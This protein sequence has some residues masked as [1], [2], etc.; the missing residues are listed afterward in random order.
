MSPPALMC[1]VMCPKK[2]Y[3]T[4][5]VVIDETTPLPPLRLRI[6]PNTTLRITFTKG[7]AAES[8]DGDPRAKSTAFEIVPH[9]GGSTGWQALGAELSGLRAGVSWGSRGS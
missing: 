8:P 2:Q 7:E 6:S 1:S 5:S 3:C 4:W 9:D